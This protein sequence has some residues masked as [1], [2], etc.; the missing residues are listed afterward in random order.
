MDERWID[1]KRREDFDDQ[2]NEAAGRE[3]GRIRRFY[4]GETPIEARERKRKEGDR[5]TAL[6]ALLADPAYA[7]AYQSAWD[8][9]D[10]AQAAVDAALLDAANAIE[11]LSENIEDMEARAHQ[12]DGEAV[13]RDED[14]TFYQPDGT[15]VPWED[16]RRIDRRSDAPS[17]EAYLMAREALDNATIRRNHLLDVQEDVL[18]P[19]REQLSDEESP[20]SL[21]EL[22]ALTERL[23]EIAEDAS[24]APLTARFEAATIGAADTTIPEE[25]VELNLSELSSPLSP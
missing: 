22:D 7:R 12:L 21:E 23:D 9:F 16:E 20:L 5:R 3:V 1:K 4:P 10:R 11:R 19:A 15:P 17:F 24:P 6:M 14:G 2:Q 18:D 25:S 13:F 8:A